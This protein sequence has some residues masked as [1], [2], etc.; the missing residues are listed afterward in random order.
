MSAN[1]GE[2][3]TPQE[4]F[5]REEQLCFRTITTFLSWTERWSLP[6]EGEQPPTPKQGYKRN[7]KD[8][9]FVLLTSL[10]NV[11]VRH[12][13]VLAIVP[14]SLKNRTAQSLKIFL[15]HNNP[16]DELPGRYIATT[17]PQRFVQDDMP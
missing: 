3:K 1:D 4:L 8:R 10:A 17:N 13:E 2:R 12:K 5:S 14:F 7:S 9:A 15:E 16:A 6:A 11:L